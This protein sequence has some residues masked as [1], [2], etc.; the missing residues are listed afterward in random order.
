MV[1]SIIEL[2]FLNWQNEKVSNT[3]KNIDHY[4]TDIHGCFK[5]LPFK[6]DYSGPIPNND[7][8]PQINIKSYETDKFGNFLDNNNNYSGPRINKT[9]RA[10]EAISLDNYKQVKINK[11]MKNRYKKWSN[12]FMKGWFT[13]KN[14]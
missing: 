4:E 14:T 3:Y 10:L 8:N 12:N 11:A 9:E 1:D 13:T 5:H 2:D 7:I 6:V